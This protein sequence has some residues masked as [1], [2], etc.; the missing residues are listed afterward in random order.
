MQKIKRAVNLVSNMGMRYVLF[1]VGYALKKKAGLLKKEFPVDTPPLD[2]LSIQEWKLLPT[3]FFFS[4]KQD[5]KVPVEPDPSLKEA[6]EKILQ[7]KLLFFSSIEYNLGTDFDWITN[8]DT[9]FKYDI[10]K[11]WSDIN[12]YSKEAGDIKFV[13]EKSRFSFLY[14][15]IRYDYHFKKD[16][17][18]FVFSEIENWIDSNPINQGPNYKCSQEISLRILNW[19]FAL[20]YYK[21]SNALSPTL[22]HKIV[23]SMYWQAKHVYSNINFSRIAVRNNHAITETLTLYLVGLLYPFFPEAGK[24]KKEGKEWFEK[25]VGYQIY[26]DGTFLQFS[27]NYHRVVIQ[28]LTWAISLAKANNESFNKVVYDRAAASIDF[29]VTCMNEKD[30][31]LPNYGAND[32]FFLS[33]LARIPSFFQGSLQAI[34]FLIFRYNRK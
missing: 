29:L 31:N 23:N 3:E 13:W 21:E 20:Q 33:V 18:S 4:V 1:R 9:G 22:F 6:A 2:F 32:G 19:T 14:T 15:L 30:G 16:L 26:P 17:S 5:L 12:D 10:S 8:P 27:M 11:H 28:L 24:W 34:S 7:G 25:E